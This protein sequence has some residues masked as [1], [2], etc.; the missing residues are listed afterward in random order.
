VDDTIYLFIIFDGLTQLLLS[1]KSAAANLQQ[2][3]G[4]SLIG[5]LTHHIRKHQHLSPLT[6]QHPSQLN[7]KHLS[8]NNMSSAGSSS[9]SMSKKHICSLRQQLRSAACRSMLV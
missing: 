8:N 4:G 7:I 5:S 6:L 9:S 1:S 3:K 2:T